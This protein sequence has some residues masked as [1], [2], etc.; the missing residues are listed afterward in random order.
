MVAANDVSNMCMA[1]VWGSNWGVRAAK[2]EP[3]VEERVRW[4][5]LRHKAEG[6][7]ERRG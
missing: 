7:R 6:G 2:P 5:R 4:R 1:A 3:C